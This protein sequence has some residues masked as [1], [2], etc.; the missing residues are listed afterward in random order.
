MSLIFYGRNLTLTIKGDF[1]ETE[2]DDVIEC[3]CV[4]CFS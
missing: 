3:F 1:Y 4:S 2:D